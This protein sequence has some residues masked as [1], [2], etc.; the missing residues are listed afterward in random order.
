MEALIELRNR[1]LDDYLEWRISEETHRA[2]L[3]AIA[4]EVDRLVSPDR[5]AP[6]KERAA[7][8][9]AEILADG[10]TLVVRPSRRPRLPAS[11]TG[12]AVTSSVSVA[13]TRRATRPRSVKRQDST[14]QG[15]T[16]SGWR[17]RSS[18]R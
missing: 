11:N 12:T 5:Q 14:R 15:A 8:V 16:R 7:R 18:Q 2:D 9:V 13:R 10:Q 4:V 17:G 1:I 6:I 3:G